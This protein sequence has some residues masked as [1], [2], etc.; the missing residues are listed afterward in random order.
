MY[1]CTNEASHSNTGANGSS[2]KEWN[3]FL[4]TFLELIIDLNAAGE[5]VTF[6]GTPD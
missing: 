2:N 3:G 6:N 5:S 1:E 4:L